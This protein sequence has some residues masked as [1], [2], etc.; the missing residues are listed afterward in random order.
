MSWNGS[1]SLPLA[2]E[3]RPD[4][5]ARNMLPLFLLFCFFFVALLVVV[6]SIEKERD[7]KAGRMTLGIVS[8]VPN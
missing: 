5:E 7:E 4:D 6:V 3:R 2:A 1:Y 8:D